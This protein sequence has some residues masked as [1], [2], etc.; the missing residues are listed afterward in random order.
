MP[1]CDFC[2]DSRGKEK[3]GISTLVSLFNGVPSMVCRLGKLMIIANELAGLDS[4][5]SILADI[6]KIEEICPY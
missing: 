2:P 3:A 5:G 6:Q 1:V 4:H